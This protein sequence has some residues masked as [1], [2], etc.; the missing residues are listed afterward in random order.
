M[1]KA[2]EAYETMCRWI[3]KE[4]DTEKLLNIINHSILANSYKGIAECIVY[5]PTHMFKDE[6]QIKD[7]VYKVRNEGYLVKR[8]DIPNEVVLTINW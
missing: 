1:T 6:D 4:G 3:D 8:N 5:L 2:V 7:I